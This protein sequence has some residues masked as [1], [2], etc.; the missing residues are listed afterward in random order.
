MWILTEDSRNSHLPRRRP[1]LQLQ[2][3]VRFRPRLHLHRH[4]TTSPGHG[5]LGTPHL[6]LRSDSVQSNAP[7]PPHRPPLRPRE[8]PL[9]ALSPTGPAEQ[10]VQADAGVTEPAAHFRG[11]PGDGAARRGTLPPLRLAGVT[12]LLAHHVQLALLPPPPAVSLFPPSPTDPLVSFP[13]NPAPLSSPAAD[14][15]SPSPS[16]SP[17]SAAT[18]PFSRHLPHRLF[19]LRLGETPSLIPLTLPATLR[20]K[21]PGCS[22]R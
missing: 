14:P 10:P 15:G 19:L 2:G 12:A 7:S 18:S 8:L 3:F 6:L 21:L 11:D 4:H 17:A 13:P 20:V 22:Q 16:I 1:S 9:A 5:V